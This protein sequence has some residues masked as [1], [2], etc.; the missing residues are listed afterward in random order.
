TPGSDFADV[1]IRGNPPSDVSGVF[2]GWLFVNGSLSI[3]GDFRMR[4][5]VY[6][7]NEISYH[8]TGTGRIEGALISRNIRRLSPTAIDSDAASSALITYNCAYART[9]GQT[10]P[11]SWSMTP[12][13]YMELCDSCS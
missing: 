12:G 4:G 9:G 5:L 1:A 3:D 8:R 11:N 6:A 7:Q 2:S 10:I 13:T